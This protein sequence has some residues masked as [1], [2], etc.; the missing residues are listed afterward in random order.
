MSAIPNMYE[1]VKTEIE[2]FGFSTVT[3]MTANGVTVMRT[4]GFTAKNLPEFSIMLHA[5]PTFVREMINAIAP[6]W[7]QICENRYTSIN[8]PEKQAEEMGTKFAQLVEA[9][10]S[11]LYGPTEVHDTLYGPG[12]YR[13][14]GLRFS[15][16]LGRF[17]EDVGYLSTFLQ[18][19][20]PVKKL[21]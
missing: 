12:E 4:I 10:L 14:K 1:I 6:H 21:H 7:Q 20:W 18:G 15:D 8:L 19:I 17:P 5:C 11:Q 3:V 16:S 13:V 9:D 2:Q